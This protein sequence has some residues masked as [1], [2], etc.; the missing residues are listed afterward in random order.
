VT[1][2]LKAS[3]VG[4][5]GYTAKS[6]MNIVRKQMSEN[7]AEVEKVRAECKSLGKKVQEIFKFIHTLE[8]KFDDYDR[9]INERLLAINRGPGETLMRH[10]SS[11]QEL[12]HF[13]SKGSTLQVRDLSPTP[14]AETQRRSLSG[15]RYNL[16][17]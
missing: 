14:N 17:Y 1:K 5:V 15:G 6:D 4:A 8:D 16:T 7:V 11:L 9:N 12:S 2:S 10:G 13:Q 3:A